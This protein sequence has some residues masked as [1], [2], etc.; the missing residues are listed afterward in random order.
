MLIVLLAVVASTGIACA[1][2]QS[3]YYFVVEKRENPAG[4]AIAYVYHWM[5]Y[6]KDREPS[7]NTL[8]VPIQLQE[9][10][11]EG[12]KK[13][14]APYLSMHNI[15]DLQ[16][17]YEDGYCW[18]LKG[19]SVVETYTPPPTYTRTTTTSPA[20]QDPQEMIGIPLWAFTIIV[21]AAILLLLLN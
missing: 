18:K 4:G 17:Y 10:N 5:W 6:E 20:T 19:A 7:T 8:G 21:A 1:M 15:Q 3:T 12:F 11:T 9:P 16:I 2:E 14:L 13:A